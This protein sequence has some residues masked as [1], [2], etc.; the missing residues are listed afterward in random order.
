MEKTASRTSPSS[1][2]PCP[3]L[4]IRRTPT[5]SLPSPPS[6]RSPDPTSSSRRLSRR[7]SCDADAEVDIMEDRPRRQDEI[8]NEYDLNRRPTEEKMGEKWK[9]FIY[10]IGGPR[11][12]TRAT[13]N[14]DS[15]KITFG[16]LL[17]FKAKMGYSLRDFMYYKKRCGTDIAFL[18][19]LDY[20]E[21]ALRMVEKFQEEK[22]IRLVVSKSEEND[23]VEYEITPIKRR[24]HEEVSEE[25]FHDEDHDVYKLWLHELPQDAENPEFKDDFREDTIK[26]YREWLRR[27]GLL[28]DIH[29]YL[30]DGTIQEDESGGSNETPTQFPSHARRPKPSQKERVVDKRKIGR[31]TMKGFAA[32]AKRF[33]LASEKLNIDFSSTLGGP[34]GVNYRL[35]IDEIVL[36]TR[37]RTPL[38]GVTKW[39]DVKQS[40]KDKIAR[41]IMIRWDLENNDD[42]KAR[43]WKIAKERYR[44]WR[45]QL[46]STYKAYDSYHQRM[47]HKP[48]D[49]DII[50]WHYLVLYFGTDKF[51]RISSKNTGNSQQRKTLH[52]TGSKPFSQVS[53]E[54]RDLETG[55]EPNDLAL[56]K[57]TRSKEGRWCSEAAE[58]IYET[59]WSKITERIESDASLLSKNE[60]SHILRQT[61]KETTGCRT[62]KGPRQGYL[63]KYPTRSQLMNE[64][65]EEQARAAA[66]AAAAQQK[67]NETQAEVEKLKE[68]LNI[69]AAE[70]ESDKSKI[71]QLEQQLENTREE[72]RREFL[73]LM[74][75]QKEASAQTVVETPMAMNNNVYD[76]PTA[77]NTPSLGEHVQQ[78]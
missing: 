6:R 18:Q 15:A 45:A 7:R 4:I 76:E 48:E 74:A 54:Q 66:L 60:E 61:Y 51:Q 50:E 20:E 75:Q 47:R 58:Q 8:T 39:A 71:L 16:N 73:S 1:R 46:S 2:S 77:V 56:W 21:D 63:A 41:D 5:T 26:T 35:F 64:R 53:Y 49:L 67:N 52:L 37:K 19:I 38:I 34:V 32:N 78:V 33:K 65:I 17:K 12:Q 11:D 57:S 24:R 43:I 3:P 42:E 68:Q 14:I 70:R 40:V 72:L 13:L 44:G 31:G 69:Q 28:Q 29:A 27:E 10:F 59:T 62:N 23:Q 30:D 9:V 55:E 36:F 22:E 25:R